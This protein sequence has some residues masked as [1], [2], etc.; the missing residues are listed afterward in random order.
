M[1]RETRTLSKFPIGNN[2][3]AGEHDPEPQH[4]R[5]SD[6]TAGFYL[7]RSLGSAANELVIDIAPHAG[8]SQ[9]FRENQTKPGTLE[10]LSLE[11]AGA[12]F[13]PVRY[14]AGWA[15][16]EQAIAPQKIPFDARLQS[17]ENALEQWHTAR[18][19]IP[20]MHEAYPGYFLI[21]PCSA[22]RY[23]LA[24][25]CAPNLLA[26]ADTRDRGGKTFDSELIRQ[27]LANTQKTLGILLAKYNWVTEQ[28]RL[29]DANQNKIAGR[30]GAIIGVAL[31]A[32]ALYLGQL[33]AGNKAALTPPSLRLDNAQNAGAD[34]TAHTAGKWVST[35]QVKRRV[36]SKDRKKYSKTNLL[37]AV[38]HMRFPGEPLVNTLEAIVD[39]TRTDELAEVGQIVLA[40][41]N[42]SRK[43]GCS[44]YNHSPPE[45]TMHRVA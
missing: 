9:Y 16:A 14:A 40:A 15:H 18:E 12:N 45:K 5:L 1:E 19:L 26:I 4:D 29:P 7:Q 38:H 25:D 8:Y 11:T 30:H 13:P 24:I 20:K 37:C 28:G 32:G 39:G 42:G 2:V 36:T 31:E 10:L 35:A 41:I 17:I 3:I 23:Q 27:T 44:K 43:H 34:L 6:T 33:A 21:W 22:W